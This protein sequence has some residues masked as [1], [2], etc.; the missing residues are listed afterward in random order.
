[1]P[2]DRHRGVSLQRQ[3]VDRIEE[4]IQN[5]PERGYK[6]IADFVT[7]AVRKRCEELKILVPTSP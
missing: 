1:M 4:Y 7:D 6:S 2:V 5:H 3:L